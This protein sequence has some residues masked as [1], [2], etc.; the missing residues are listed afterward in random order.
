MKPKTFDLIFTV[1]AGA[2]FAIK[3]GT[4]DATTLVQ[5]EILTMV[6][7]PKNIHD[8]NAIRLDR[9]GGL[10]AGYVPQSSS[11]WL[12]AMLDHGYMLQAR[13]VVVEAADKAAPKITL[14]IEMWTAE[15][16]AAAY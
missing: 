8:P 2:S 1:L 6:R 10:K 11:A 4:L 9:A 13:V 14:A 3:S 16:L 7:E 5:D 15:A 12:A